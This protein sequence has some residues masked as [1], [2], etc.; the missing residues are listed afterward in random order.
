M[1]DNT[2]P[3][4]FFKR[5]S[6]AE[7]REYRQWARDNYQIGQRIP[8]IWHPVLRDECNKMNQ[9]EVDEWNH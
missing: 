2:L 4:S 1:K 5:L 8:L 6:P 3:D 7:E 9:E